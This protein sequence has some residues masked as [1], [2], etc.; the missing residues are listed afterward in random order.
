MA[1][2]TSPKASQR[3]MHSKLKQEQRNNF[4][5]HRE[6][7]IWRMI[8]QRQSMQLSIHHELQCFLLC[9]L[10]ELQAKLDFCPS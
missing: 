7:A 9:T 5:H 1:L 10:F 2:T 6:V 8:F 3:N 4:A